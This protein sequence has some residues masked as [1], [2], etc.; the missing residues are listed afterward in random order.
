[1]VEPIIQRLRETGSPS[2]VMSGSKD[3][4]ALFGNLKP[5]PLPPGR[6]RLVTRRGPLL[7]QTAHHPS[8]S[9]R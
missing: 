9:D 4:G 6:G 1:M 7:I 3:E 2:L 8:E 5:E